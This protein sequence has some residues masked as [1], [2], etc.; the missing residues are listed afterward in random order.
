[1]MRLHRSFPARI[2]LVA[3]CAAV[4]AVFTG[5]AGYAYTLKA[6]SPLTPAVASD[7]AQ[8]SA[9]PGAST[10]VRVETE[11]VTIRPGGFEPAEI[12]R[13]QGEFILAVDNMS[14]LRELT[15]SIDREHGGHVQERH[16]T[17]EQLKWK[18]RLNLPP[19]RYVVK[20][21][22]HPDWVFTLTIKSE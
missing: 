12:T 10:T 3:A 8:D 2:K 1:M 5:A 19:G 4:A 18:T 21:A 20:E 15:L 9:S 16:V 14:G 17:L 11:R 6:A 13:P 22:A 7:A